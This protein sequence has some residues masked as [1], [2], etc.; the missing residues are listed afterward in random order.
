[1]GVKVSSLWDKRIMSQNKPMIPVTCKNCGGFLMYVDTE[2]LKRK[3]LASHPKNCHRRLER[4]HREKENQKELAK[5]RA[6][7]ER[8]KKERAKKEQT[9]LFGFLQKNL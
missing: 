8:A 1:V 5:E 3:V 9:S 4:L 2:E 6:K 7:K